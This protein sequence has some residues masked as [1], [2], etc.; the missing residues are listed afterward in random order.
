[1]KKIINAVNNKTIAAFCLLAA[2]SP[3]FADV[4]T[5]GG[6]WGKV[7]DKLFS[8]TGAVLTIAA[9]VLGFR[10]FFRKESIVDCWGLVAGAALIA[11][12]PEMPSWFGFK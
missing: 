12:A 8:W 1:M 10:V 7:Q 5:G 11:F 9:V 4:S 2:S 6:F 3:A